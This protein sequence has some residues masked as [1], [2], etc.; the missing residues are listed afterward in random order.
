[1]KQQTVGSNPYNATTWHTSQ[2]VA[3][4]RARCRSPVTSG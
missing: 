1:M 2:A 3:I 4:A